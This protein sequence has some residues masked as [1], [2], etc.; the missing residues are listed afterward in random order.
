MRIAGTTVSP[1]EGEP[2]MGSW[3]VSCHHLVSADTGRD[4]KVTGPK[5]EVQQ[6]RCGGR[7]TVTDGNDKLGVLSGELH[8]S[9]AG[10]RELSGTV[11]YGARFVAAAAALAFNRE[12]WRTR[13]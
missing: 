6:Q 9:G 5:D 7:E 3:F 13:S 8:Q 10:A 11:P 1:K 2:R 4:R 12:Q